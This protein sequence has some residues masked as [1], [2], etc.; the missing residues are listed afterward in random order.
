MGSITPY[1]K[2]VKVHH[3]RIWQ[4]LADGIET[5]IDIDDIAKHNNAYPPSQSSDSTKDIIINQVPP[6]TICKVVFT[7]GG[8]MC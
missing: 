2:M 4:A 7:S 6:K 8:S 1:F 3:R 5:K